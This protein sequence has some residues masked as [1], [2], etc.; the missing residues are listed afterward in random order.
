MKIKPNILIGTTIF[1]SFFTDVMPANS[2]TFVFNNESVLGNDQSIYEFTLTL[3][4]G[5]R[6]RFFD[7][8]RL[9]GF[10]D[11]STDSGDTP[12]PSQ[13]SWAVNQNSNRNQMIWF[14]NQSTINSPFSAEFFVNATSGINADLILTSDLEGFQPVEV[15]LGQ[16][17]QSIPESRAC[18]QS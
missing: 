9:S 11:F 6:I 2:A 10:P 4:D 1:C 16:E 14:L 3:D 15:S 12:D 17:N 18:L 13:G 8:L 7:Q 5:D